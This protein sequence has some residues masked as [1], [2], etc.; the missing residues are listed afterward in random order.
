LRGISGLDDGIFDKGSACFL[1]AGNVQRGLGQQREVL[2]QVG[3]Q[4]CQLFLVAAGEEIDAV[5]SWA[6]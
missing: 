1:W 3:K 2:R 4:F 5:G 6:G